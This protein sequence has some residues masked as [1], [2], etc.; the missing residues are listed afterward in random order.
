MNRLCVP[1]RSY[2]AEVKLLREN[3]VGLQGLCHITGGGFDDN[4]RRVLP[5]GMCARYN[6]FEFTDV[7]NELQSIGDLDRPTMTQV[8][9]CGYGMIVF[10]DRSEQL[11]LSQLLPEAVE[12]GVVEARSDE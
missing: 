3:G 5:E 11:L 6:D 2:L 9:N 10:V 8:F 12:I 4:V 1:H 7:F